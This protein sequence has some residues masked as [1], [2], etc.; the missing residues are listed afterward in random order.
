MIL[1][2]F[3]SKKSLTAA[4]TILPTEQTTTIQD[5]NFIYIFETHYRFT[6]HF[7]WHAFPNNNLLHTPSPH[8]K[9]LHSPFFPEFSVMSKTSV[10]Q[11]QLALQKA[12]QYL[13]LLTICEKNP[14]NKAAADVS[15]MAICKKNMI[16][17][18]YIA[19]TVTMVIT[20]MTATFISVM[21]N[22]LSSLGL[23]ESFH[24]IPEML[25]N[26]WNGFT[27][28]HMYRTLYQSPDPIKESNIRTSLIHT[29]IYT[30]NKH[31]LTKY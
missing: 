16:Y 10:L 21:Q 7:P 20:M 18:I 8:P 12:R 2:I 3:L 27:F 17:G 24:F 9:H 15:S 26:L 19:K 1:I 4:S 6:I 22:Y 14:S 25:H 13:G 29:Y 28:I 5:M 23:Q 30:H 11:S 31:M